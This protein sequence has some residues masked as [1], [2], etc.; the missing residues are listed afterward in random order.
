MVGASPERAVLV[1]MNAVREWGRTKLD[2][3]GGEVVGDWVLDD[4][5]KLFGTVDVTDTE[6]VQQLHYGVSARRGSERDT[7]P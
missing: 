6:L 7:N 4:A 5:Q 2:G 3:V 1:S